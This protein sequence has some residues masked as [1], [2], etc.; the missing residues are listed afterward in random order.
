M[1]DASSGAV[2]EQTGHFPWERPVML[3]TGLL[4]QRTWR[5]A[6]CMAVTSHHHIL[7]T[8]FVAC[9]SLAVGCKDSANC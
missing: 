7:A 3:S 1:G 6:G 8:H 2:K 5:P 9:T 4:S